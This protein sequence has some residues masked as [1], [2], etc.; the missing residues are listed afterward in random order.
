MKPSF[1]ALASLLL[2]TGSASSAQSFADTE[3]AKAELIKLDQE[4]AA[5][6]ARKDARTIYRIV[7]P[8]C[9]FTEWN[10]KVYNKAELMRNLTKSTVTATINQPHDYD[11][12]FFG[13]DMAVLRHNMTFVGTIDGKKE[14]GEFRR[15]HVFVRRDGRWQVVD[16]QSVRVTPATVARK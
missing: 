1:L 11:V 4:W 10:G 8:E 12:R 5:A 15:M 14:S 9:L 6:D 3:K 16:S 7:A 13:P 2:F